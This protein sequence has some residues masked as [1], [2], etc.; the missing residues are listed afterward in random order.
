MRFAADPLCCAILK[1]M[2]MDISSAQDASADALSDLEIEQTI[3]VI[4][5]GLSDGSHSAYIHKSTLMFLSN[6][7]N[8]RWIVSQRIHD[9]LFLRGILRAMGT[10]H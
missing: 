8:E 3:Q 9:Q 10:V 4:V 5:R 6:I 7:T 2:T 1:V